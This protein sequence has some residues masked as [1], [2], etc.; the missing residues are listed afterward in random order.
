MRFIA[1]ALLGIATNLDNLLLGVV[2]GLRG[3]RIGHRQNL[4]IAAGSAVASFLCCY[5]ASFCINLG[6][7]PKYLG[8]TLL[9]LLGIWPML[10]K[11]EKEG[12]A[13]ENAD[14]TGQDTVSWTETLTLTGALALNC[15]VASFGAGLTGMDALP[16]ALLVGG[17]SFLAVWAGNTLG[18]VAKVGVRA[19]RLNWL[20]SGVMILL[21]LMALFV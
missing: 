20:A 19:E 6:R 8:A 18:R 15:L 5:L 12:A 14:D 7:L 1:A 3:K 21:G 17:F 9:I 16:V 11:K 10:P 4:C 2:Y 13:T